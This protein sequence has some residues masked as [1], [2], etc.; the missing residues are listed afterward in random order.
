MLNIRNIFLFI[1]YFIFLKITALFKFIKNQLND[2]FF[3]NC[4][5]SKAIYDDFAIGLTSTITRYKIKY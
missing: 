4:L 3:Y 2:L 1:L 5:W